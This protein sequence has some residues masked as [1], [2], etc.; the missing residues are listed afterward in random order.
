MARLLSVQ[1]REEFGIFPP[2]TTA[3]QRVYDPVRPEKTPEGRPVTLSRTEIMVVQESAIFSFAV[4]II[5]QARKGLTDD[6]LVF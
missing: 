1:S 2:T 5:E 4:P 6:Q 3:I